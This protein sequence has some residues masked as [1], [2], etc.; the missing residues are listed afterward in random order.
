MLK[1][2]KAIYLGNGEHSLA[3]V[4]KLKDRLEEAIHTLC[5]LQQPGHPDSEQA[6]KE[7]E[8][9]TRQATND[10]NDAL[11]DIV[12]A[13][14]SSP[15]ALQSRLA[16]HPPIDLGNGCSMSWCERCESYWQCGCVSGE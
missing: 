1:F 4:Q 16:S 2:Q 14:G 12:R 8:E 10:L 11:I 13:L 9:F 7:E 5:G 6:A 3:E 15:E